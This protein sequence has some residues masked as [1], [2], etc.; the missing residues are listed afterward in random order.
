MDG[1]SAGGFRSRLAK[2]VQAARRVG[3]SGARN[4]LDTLAVGDARAHGSMS[5]PE[6]DLR[7]RLRA[8]GRQL[9]DRHNP[10]TGVQA[11]DR[12]AHE[13]AYEHW[14]RMLFARFLAE[15]DL[16]I[17]PE[18]GVPVSLSDCEDLGREQGQD[19]WT[20]AGRFA[21]RM[22]PRIFRSDDPALEVRLAPETRQELERLVEALPAGGFTA[23][24]ALG[25]TYQFWQAERKEAV[26]KSGV[27]IGPAELP[28][29]TQLFTE[30][31]M[32]LFLLHNTV[33]AWRA[34]RILAAQPELAGTATSEE[35]LRQAVRLE[36]DGGYDFSY[37]RFVREPR[38]GD[39]AEQPT[40]PW[41]PAAGRFEGWPRAAADLRVFDPCCGSGHFLIECL[42][43]L[44]RLRMEEE[45]FAPGDAIDA[46]LHDN[47]FGLEVDPRCT[48]IAAFNLALTAWSWPGAG[49]HRRL[50]EL[51][52]ACSGLAPNAPRDEWTRLSDEAAD[53]GGLPPKRDLLGVDDSLLSAPLRNSLCALHDLFAQAPVLGSLI[54]PRSVEADLFQHDY[55]SV[56]ALLGGL[57]ERERGSDGGER[58]ERAVAAQGM[59]RAAELLAGRYH[60]VITNVPY[61]ARSKQGDVLKQFAQDRYPSAKGDLATLFV[62]RSF[63]WLGKRGGL[64]LVTPQNWLFLKSYRK[65][66]ET[67]LKGRTWNLVARL[68]EHAFEDPQAAGAFAAMN[69]LSADR[70]TRD[71]RMTCVDVSAVRGERPIRASEKAALLRGGSDAPEAVRRPSNGAMRTI[72]Q[73]A[74]LGNPDSMLA[75]RNSASRERLSRVA[76]AYQG[77]STGDNCAAVLAHWEL[78]CVG[79]GWTHLQAASDQAVPF[80]GRTHLLRRAVLESE[81]TTATVRGQKAWRRDGVAVSQTGRLI[82]TR[83]TGEHF[84]N[85]IP[86]VVPHDAAHLSAVCCFCESGELEDA[87]RVFNPK[88]SVDNG[89][90]GK[91]PFNLPHWQQVAAQKYPNGLPEPYSNDPTQ[92]IFHGHPRGSVAW[93]EGNKHIVHG[94]PRI[95]ATVLQ[96]AVAR[97][98]G[99]RW[100]AEQDLDLRMAAEA[101]VWIARC[102][103][104][105]EFAD[106]DGIVCLPAV[107]GEFAAADRLRQLLAA[108]YGADWSPETER[109]LLVAAAG[110]SEPV[111]SI[112]AW[113]RDR[114]FAEHCQQFLQRP[115][116]WHV[117]DGRRDGFHAL[118]NYHRLAGAD[119]EGRRTLEALAY[120]HLG[121]W[122]ARQDADRN[123]GIDGADGRL[124]A[125]HDLRHQLERII[126]GEPPCDVFIRWKP[127][128]QQPIGWEPDI[129]DGVRVNIRPFMSAELAKVGRGGVLRVKPKIA[130]GKDRGKEALMPRKRWRPAWVE[131]DGINEVEEVDEDLELRPRGEYPWFWS[132]PGNDTLTERTDFLGGAEFD[133]NRWNDLHYTSTLKR[134]ARSR[135]RHEVS[136]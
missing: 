100:P 50:P 31:Y 136:R 64:A 45:R 7:R 47:L 57:L 23:R 4:A 11:I 99:Y 117:W 65:L 18:A 127:L 131:E 36:A 51:N 63:G 113:L 125:A 120:R 52:L 10:G 70:P 14:H 108:A 8:H 61:L 25:W 44:V 126:A 48:Q 116:V 98:L 112:D 40:G 81:H 71:W 74:Q 12:V 34:G 111:D 55:D 42:D 75:F 3:E 114:F 60:L 96:V 85:V 68:G 24:D 91:I 95:D 102:R 32:V 46:V 77:T 123:Q 54:D 135:R 107:G 103:D 43:L 80:S 88:L 13:I 90:F 105:A 26:N 39:E 56:R 53:A 49:G 134:A 109:Q 9:G 124:T 73:R 118:V 15:N 66:R 128:D 84:S 130:W 106:T 17:E 20:L 6:Q 119:G 87:L 35:E 93:D 21:E 115:F 94:P 22:L 72:R 59:A 28:A 83:Y 1:F 38:D 37:L 76:L 86:V 101:R 104:L 82:P 132:C 30:R 79:E 69:L 62:S 78:P 27:K 110:R 92:W 5:A 67:L 89:Y 19:R 2:T 58:T 29:V 122:I 97:L 133:G 41:R 16:L 33:G 121:D 129:N